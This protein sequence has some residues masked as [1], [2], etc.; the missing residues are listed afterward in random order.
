[1]TPQLYIAIA[2]FVLAAF[3]AVTTLSA[4]MQSSRIGGTIATVVGAAVGIGAIYLH[5]RLGGTP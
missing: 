4:R 5:S 2:G 1:V 3:G